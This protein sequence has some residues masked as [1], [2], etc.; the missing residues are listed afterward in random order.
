MGRKKE[1]CLF[2]PNYCLPLLRYPPLSKRISKNDE[3]DEADDEDGA[4]DDDGDD[5]GAANN[6]HTFLCPPS[7]QDSAEKLGKGNHQ[8]WPGR[9]EP[10]RERG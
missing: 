10:A 6:I 7:G 1:K 2:W 9:I 5:D 8:A 4:V 3:D